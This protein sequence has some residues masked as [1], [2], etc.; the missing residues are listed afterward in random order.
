MNFVKILR[1]VE[2][3]VFV[4][5]TWIVFVPKTFLKI[6][7]RPRW[8][9]D[10]VQEESEKAPEVRYDAY[11]SPILFWIMVAVVPFVIVIRYYF[12]F[13]SSSAD[14]DFVKLGFENTVIIFTV[15]MVGLPLGIALG[16]NWFNSAANSRTALE[17]V[18]LTQCYCVAPFELTFV[19]GV[20]R[21]MAPD[22][23]QPVPFV[24]KYWYVVIAIGF[25]WLWLAETS[26]IKADTANTSTFKSVTWALLYIL[27]GLAVIALIGLGIIWG[28]GNLL[29]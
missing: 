5:A 4:A 27:P 3:F 24:G 29:D 7:V 19:A 22:F 28:L 23:K 14:S 20:L 18:F 12:S 6:L 1:S 17:P 21:L 10:Y 16:R 25:I 2:E 9:Y 26:V 13:S 11:V 8:A 15:F